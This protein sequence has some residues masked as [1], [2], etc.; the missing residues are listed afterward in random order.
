MKQK[1]GELVQMA[2]SEYVDFDELT[3]T[4]LPGKSYYDIVVIEDKKRDIRTFLTMQWRDSGGMAM[5][6]DY[7]PKNL[8]M[9][10][11]RFILP[12]G[13]L[14]EIQRELVDKSRSLLAQS[15]MLDHYV[16]SSTDIDLSSLTV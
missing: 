4:K 12:I 16:K 15:K 6:Q 3:T 13:K 2:L 14:I 8:A 7:F 10:N 1:G 9:E 11:E 5:R